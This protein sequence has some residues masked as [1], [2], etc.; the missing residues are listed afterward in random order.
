MRLRAVW[1]GRRLGFGLCLRDLWA[2]RACGGGGFGAAERER[3]SVCV[4]F[5]TLLANA[6]STVRGDGCV[7]RGEKKETHTKAHP[8]ALHTSNTP[9]L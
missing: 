8:S 1:R 2:L 5:I 9:M 7:G 4:A 6:F 3:W